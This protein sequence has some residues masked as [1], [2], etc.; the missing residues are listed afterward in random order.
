MITAP[1]TT[2]REGI[3]LCLFVTLTAV[4]CA[5]LLGAAALVPA[6]PVV[7]PFL[8]VACIT[9][10]MAAACE[11]PRAVAALRAGR[12]SARPMD[13]ARA[14]DTRALARLRR[15]LDQLPETQHPLGL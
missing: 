3:L 12:R 1:P 14:V 8:I 6:P 7:L 15:Q 11:L 4:M 13:R 9:C 2:R 5:G 10:P